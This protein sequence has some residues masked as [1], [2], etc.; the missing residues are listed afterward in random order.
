MPCFPSLATQFIYPILLLLTGYYLFTFFIS[1]FIYIYIYLLLS[2]IP[3]YITVCIYLNCLFVFSLLHTCLSQYYISISV[4]YSF[5]F[6]CVIFYFIY[7][8]LFLYFKLLHYSISYVLESPFTCVIL[9]THICC[10][11]EPEI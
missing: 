7:Y 9:F 3:A 5:L 6:H 8:I 11:K 1:P 4:L 10:W 2:F